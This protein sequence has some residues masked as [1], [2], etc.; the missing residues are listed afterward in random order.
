MAWLKNALI[1]LLVTAVIV[2]YVFTE[3]E[4]GYWIIVI[5]TPLIL[6]LKIGA[7]AS[8]AAKIVRKTGKKDVESAPNWFYHVLYA[9]NFSLLL[10]AYLL[11]ASPWILAGGWAVIW[12]LS[13]VHEARSSKKK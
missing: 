4:W 3:A 11:H 8:G 9:T 13:A 7:I 2:I 12:I 10:Y 1:D 6:L 5:Y